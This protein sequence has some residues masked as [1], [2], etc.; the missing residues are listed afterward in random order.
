M[1][2]AWVAHCYVG[3]SGY[4]Y[5][6]WQGEGRFYPIDLKQK[7][8]L[9]FYCEH[10]D[11]VEMDGTWYRMPAENAVQQWIAGTPKDFK[12]TFKIH[13]NVSHVQRL[14]EECLDNV[15]FFC[16]RVKPVLDAGK[17]ASIFVQLPPNFKRNDERLEAFLSKLPK[18]MPWAVEFRN[19]TWH[20]AEVEEIMRRHGVAW[21][22]WDT[23][24]AAGERRD[25][26]PF[27]YSRMRRSAY[28]DEQLESWVAWFRQAMDAGKNCYVF[29][30]HED[31]GSPWIDADRLLKLMR[32]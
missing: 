7:D 1:Y 5:K 8:F 4:S 15:T 27:I 30:K 12:F 16:G 25:T 17:L 13:R 22:S 9:K 14:K 21:V 32:S 10:Y 11:S 23:D 2:N 3:L 29:F 24:E 18:E 6:P 31:E 28:T 26:G 20:T 19:E